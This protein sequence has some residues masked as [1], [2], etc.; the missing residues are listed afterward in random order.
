VLVRAVGPTL[1]SFGV[2]GTLA[3]PT[4][5]VVDSNG[6]VVAT[7]DNW[8]SSLSSVFTKVG[9]FP[10]ATGSKDAALVVTLPAGVSY[11]VQ[12]SGVNS[13]IGEALVEVYEVP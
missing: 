5:R 8:D 12:V 1:A 3:D 7:N 4:L 9:A 11:T 10:L 6:V 13:V 2:P